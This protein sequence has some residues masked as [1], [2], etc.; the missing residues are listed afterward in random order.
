MYWVDRGD[1]SIPLFKPATTE[2]GFPVKS[3][4]VARYAEVSGRDVTNLDY[5]IALGLWKLAI[6]CEGVYKRFSAGA[7]GSDGSDGGAD[8]DATVKMLAARAL[9]TVEKL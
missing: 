3:E 1:D 9:E 2:P 4:L 5:F 7:Y 6:I 8:F